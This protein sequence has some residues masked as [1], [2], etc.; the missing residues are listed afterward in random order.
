MSTLLWTAIA[1]AAQ[2]AKKMDWKHDYDAALKE[3]QKDKKYVV[4]HFTGSN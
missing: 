1:L 2:G 4:V 3:A